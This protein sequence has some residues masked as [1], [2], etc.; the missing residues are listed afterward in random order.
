MRTRLPWD[1]TPFRFKTPGSA[2]R[3]L[4]SRAAIANHF[5]V[6]LHLLSYRTLKH[7]RAMAT[8]D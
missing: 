8:A 5:N 2:Q 1:D 4:S 3:F 7:L 6:Q